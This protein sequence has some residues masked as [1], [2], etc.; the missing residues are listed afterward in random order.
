MMN[1]RTYKTVMVILCLAAFLMPMAA[2]SQADYPNR[3]IELVCPYNAGGSSDLFTRLISEK[4]KEE[5][6]QP[7]VVLNKPGAGT[8]LGASYVA[9]AKPDGY[10]IYAPAGGVFVFL[11]ALT[12]GFTIRLSDFAPIGA[13]AKYP[14]VAVAHKDVPVN[15]LKEMVD[16]IRKN[17]GKMSYCSVG[18]ASSGHLLWESLKQAEHL[19]IQHIPYTGVAPALTALMGAQAQFAIFPFSSLLLK[20][21]QTKTIK[22]LGVMG[23]KSQFMPDTPTSTEQGFPYLVF[24]SYLNFCAPAKAPAAIVKKLEGALEKLIKDKALKDKIAG[25]ALEPDFLNAQQTLKYLEGEI[26][27]ADVIKKANIVSQ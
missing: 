9:N 11:H 24:D 19:D 13:S 27:W 5:L 12:P 22:L 21:A 15:N 25:L 17:P 10:T 3:T 20:Q 1:T 7:V 2:Q 6:G 23:S 4:L 16:Y 14:Q 26:K 18:I 8:A